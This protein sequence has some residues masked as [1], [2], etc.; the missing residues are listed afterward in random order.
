[1]WE[2]QIN[3]LTIALF[4]VLLAVAFMKYA[5]GEKRLARQVAGVGLL[6]VAV[7]EVALDSA[8]QASG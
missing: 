7:T 8:N 1:M 5:R 4:F 2:V 3:V 6:A